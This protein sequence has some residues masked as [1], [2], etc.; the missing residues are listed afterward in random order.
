MLYGSMYGLTSTSFFLQHILDDPRCPQVSLVH[1]V[2]C[3]SV[4]ETFEVSVSSAEGTV[5][6]EDWWCEVVRHSISILWED[7]EDQVRLVNQEHSVLRDQ[8]LY[9]AD[10]LVEVEDSDVRKRLSQDCY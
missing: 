9:S 7:S 5:D 10:S 2:F 6:A 4:E 1:V 3:P 8:F